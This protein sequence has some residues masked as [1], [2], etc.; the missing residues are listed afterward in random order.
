MIAGGS[1]IDHADV[2]RA[3]ASAEVLPYR[4]MAPST[5]GTFLRAFSFGHVRQLEAVAAEALRRAWAAGVGPGRGR[6]VVDLDST[7]TEVVGKAKQGAAYGYTKVLGYHPS[8]GVPGRDRR[9]AARPVAA[10]LGQHRPR[11][12]TLACEELVA[13]VRRAGADGEMVMRMDS[14]FWSNDTI[15]TLE[16]LDLRYTMTVRTGNQAIAAAISAIAEDGWADIGYTDSGVAQV[17]E[18]VYKGR[19]LVVRRTRL[20]D[21]YQARLWPEWRHHAFLTDLTGDATA[22]DAFHRAHAVVE[23]AIRDAKEG[24]GLAHMPSGRFAANG[25][26][27][28]CAVLA[29]NLLRWTAILG[30]VVASEELT[31]ARS[32]R[33][34]L[35]GIP[36]RLVNRSGNSVLR[37][38]EYWP[39]AD[40]FLRALR[41]RARRARLRTRVNPPTAGGAPHHPSADNFDHCHLGRARLSTNP[42]PRGRKRPSNGPGESPP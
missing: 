5:L 34:R 20:T 28:A 4:V 16:R 13:R 39:W 24:S 9:T 32:M 42:N 21:P 18:T 25:A 33:T 31:V 30:G 12:A 7:I 23:L 8:R 10:R 1:H 41:Q 26:W 3:G 2:L 14:G 40:A 38:P 36:A 19:R 35:I 29:H 15:A 22:T 6:L 27:L 37:M 11:S 17:A